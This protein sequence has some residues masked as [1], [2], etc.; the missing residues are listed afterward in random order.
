MFSVIFE[1]QPRT[2]QRDAYLSSAE[3]LRLELDE[4]SGSVD[5][6]RYN[7]LTRDGW[8]L[9]LSS[10]RDE[11]SV[12]RWRT[13]ALHQEAQEKG[14]AEILPDYHLRV[15]QLTYDTRLP[16]GCDLLEPRL[17]ETE[18]GE[19]V[20]IT[21]IDAKQIPDWVSSHNPQEIATCLGFDHNSYGD[22]ISWDVLE[23]L[24]TPGD[25][26]LFVLWKDQASAMEF[27]QST[28]VPDDARVR[29]VRVIRDYSMSDRREAPQFYADA[30]GRGTTHD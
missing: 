7:S 6:I 29:V 19:G 20:A 24:S 18:V 5:N 27:A 10:W 11:K 16:D 13:D 12:V 15:G 8:I 14:R 21:L 28:I 4:A 2:E 17:D 26:I 23:D 22:C 9:S 25:I 30:G 3:A 1:V